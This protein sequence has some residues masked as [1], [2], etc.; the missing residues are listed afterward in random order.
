MVEECAVLKK[1][2]LIGEGF[3]L[4]IEID[5]FECLLISALPSLQGIILI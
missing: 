1:Y 2:V 3:D 4:H 5:V